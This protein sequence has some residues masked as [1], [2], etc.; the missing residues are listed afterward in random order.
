METPTITQKQ[1]KKAL[2]GKKKKKGGTI[3]NIFASP[4]A[5]FWCVL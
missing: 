1:A 3:K 4:F 2:S 5:S